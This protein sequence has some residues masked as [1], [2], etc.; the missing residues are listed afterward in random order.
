MS[1]LTARAHPSI[2]HL[3]PARRVCALCVTGLIATL[4]LLQPLFCL[5]SCHLSSGMLPFLPTEAV[6]ELERATDADSKASFAFF[7]EMPAAPAAESHFLPAFW[8]GLLPL[9]VLAVAGSRL[10]LRLPH[11]R[12][13]SPQTWRWAPSP[14]PPRRLAA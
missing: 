8:P 1:N 6:H 14:P 10:L 3:Q 2:H 11:A 7:C 13:Q 9:L 4:L 12:T 5:I